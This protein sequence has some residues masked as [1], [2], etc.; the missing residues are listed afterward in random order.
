M[1]LFI[2]VLVLLGSTIS[3]GRIPEPVGYDYD[4]QNKMQAGRHWD[5]LAADTANEINKELILNEY[6]NTPVFVRQTCGDENTPCGPDQTTVFN[7]S[8]R[9]LLITELVR[10]GVPTSSVP[11]ENAITVNY[12]AQTIYHHAYRLRTI[13]PGLITALATGIMVFRDAPT[14]ILTIMMAGAVDY[15]N[16]AYAHSGHFEV[17]IT[18]SMI[19]KER[20]IYR[21]SSIYYINDKDSWHYQQPS[22]PAEIELTATASPPPVEEKT[23]DEPVELPMPIIPESGIKGSTE[24]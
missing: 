3:C 12:K 22:A 20:Y 14:E 16:M 8:F 2:L 11:S 24:I 4:T 17:V 9:D 5:I 6:I 13:K 19:D 15:A 23:A 18:T 10:L 1:R 7:E 21:N